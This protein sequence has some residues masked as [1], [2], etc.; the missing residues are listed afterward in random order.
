MSAEPWAGSSSGADL[1]AA[2][3]LH[4]VRDRRRRRAAELA[5]VCG[6]WDVRAIWKD[7]RLRGGRHP[8]HSGRRAVGRCP[9]EKSPPM[10][11][12]QTHMLDLATKSP[13]RWKDGTAQEAAASLSAAYGAEYIVDMRGE[14]RARAG[15]LTRR[16]ARRTCGYWCASRSSP[17][18]PRALMVTG[19]RHRRALNLG[20]D[21]KIKPL[22]EWGM[23]EVADIVAS[24]LPQARE[25]S[26][27]VSLFDAGSGHCRWPLNG[28]SPITSFRFCGEPV[29][30]G[31]GCWC[32]EHS[33]IA[34]L[35]NRRQERPFIPCQSLMPN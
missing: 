29:L 23:V 26:V 32:V 30:V 11:G 27:G 20:V 19:P 14:I 12:G 6:A 33:R 10:G 28:V 35:G 1:R 31:S 3:G 15:R 25:P 18:R 8:A 13:Q 17:R 16:R 5:G 22:G 4:P 9:A 34:Y 2:H 21:C 24:A 7:A